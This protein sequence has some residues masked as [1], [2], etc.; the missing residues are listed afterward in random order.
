MGSVLAGIALDLDRLG[1]HVLKIWLDEELPTMVPQSA[2][3]ACR[4]YGITVCA[5]DL[6][7]VTESDRRW[8]NALVLG[9][10]FVILLV[11]VRQKGEVLAPLLLAGYLL[12]TVLLSYYATLGAT[13]LLAHHW[14]GRPLGEIDW[15]VPYFL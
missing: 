2:Q 12:A 11:L 4:W 14:H 10:V 6:A 9:G 1:P 15:R 5:R 3:G 7:T 8:I 13:T